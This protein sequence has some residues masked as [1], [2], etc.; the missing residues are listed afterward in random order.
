MVRSVSFSPDSQRLLT[1]G[2]DK[3]IR[4]WHISGKLTP[5]MFC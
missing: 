4:I 3:M 5:K 2:D 1:A